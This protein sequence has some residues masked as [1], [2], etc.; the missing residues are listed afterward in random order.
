MTINIGDRIEVIGD[1]P[2]F[3]NSYYAGVVLGIHGDF[4][5]V[6]YEELFQTKDGPLLREMIESEQVRPYP[7]AVNDDNF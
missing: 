3:E 1:E 7:P 2:G 4:F 5:E 6:E